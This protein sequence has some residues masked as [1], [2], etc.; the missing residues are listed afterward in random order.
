M[1]VRIVI[2]IVALSALFGVAAVV[3][4]QRI[5]ALIEVSVQGYAIAGYLA[6]VLEPFLI[7]GLA[8]IACRLRQWMLPIM[9]V[10][11]AAALLAKAPLEFA[12]LALG[13]LILSWPPRG[14]LLRGP[15][16]AGSA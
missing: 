2:A 5:P 4:G 8:L 10:A 15:R 13:V 12:A 6:L 9:M 16:E 3:D 14:L 1:P 11:A 7:L